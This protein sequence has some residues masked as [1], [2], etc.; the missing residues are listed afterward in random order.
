MSDPHGPTRVIPAVGARPD[1]PGERAEDPR[2]NALLEAI[3]RAVGNDYDVL[4]EIFEFGDRAQGGIVFLA[5]ERHSTSLDMLHLVPAAGGREGYVEVLGPLRGTAQPTSNGCPNCGK[6]LRPGARVC[7]SCGATLSSGP[8]ADASNS[9]S[10]AEWLEVKRAARD[11]KYDILRELDRDALGP[12]DAGESDDIVY[13]GRSLKTSRIVALRLERAVDR[14]APAALSVEQTGI[15]DRLVE[16]SLVDEVPAPARVVERVVNPVAPPVEPLHVPPETP[17]QPPPDVR[18]RSSWIVQLRELLPRRRVV[19]ILIGVV[20]ILAAVVSTASVTSW[21]RARS[22]RIAGEDSVRA[23]VALAD[24]AR[25]DSMRQVN[26][27]QDSARADSARIARARVD[28]AQLQIAASV[29]RGTSITVDRKRVR[30]S[31][32]RLAPGTHTLSAKAAGYQTLTETLEL[33]PGQTLTWPPQLV[34]EP[35]RVDTVDKPTVASCGE[36]FRREDWARARVACEEQARTTQGNAAAE[37]MLGEMHERGL[38]VPQDYA[39]AASWFAKGAD[40]GDRDAEYRYGLLL[41]DGR[42]VRRDEA[43][44]MVFFLQSG[45]KGNM[46]AQFAAGVAY[47]RGRGVRTNRALAAA[48]YGKAA[49][50]GHSDAQLALGILYAK[51]DG[52]PR[53]ESEAIALFEKSAAQGNEGARRELAKRGRRP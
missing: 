22:A 26:A 51:G 32:I 48:Q 7:P 33:K 24:S 34:E 16:A 5:S 38:G 50:Q 30:G 20:A 43:R 42:G 53:S 21:M 23:L 12:S 47:D 31:T 19:P 28:S 36:A 41:R 1:Q 13:L 39:T 37:R 3:G 8:S 4:G 9:M 11:N 29:P 14:N 52:V 15:L 2:A 46:Y 25:Q 6:F 17:L 44:A 27:R 10:H 49:A 45:G 18:Y 40:H 35:R